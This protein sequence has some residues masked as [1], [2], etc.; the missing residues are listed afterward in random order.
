MVEIRL[1]C[2]FRGETN[3]GASDRHLAKRVAV[4][5]ILVVSGIVVVVVAQIV[6]VC[7]T[8]PSVG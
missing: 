1:Q 5:G 4:T 3:D 7:G 8:L 2:C 6:D